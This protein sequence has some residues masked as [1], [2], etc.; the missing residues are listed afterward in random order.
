M[1]LN[2]LTLAERE[3]LAYAEGFTTTAALLARASDDAIDLEA[4]Q[5]AALDAEM[6]WEK[7]EKDQERRIAILDNDLGRMED[8]LNNM[9]AFVQLAADYLKARDVDRAACT[10]S[11]ALK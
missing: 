1:L 11:E 6:D 7:L 5:D 8:R 3:R 10:L 9:A 2:T 4:A